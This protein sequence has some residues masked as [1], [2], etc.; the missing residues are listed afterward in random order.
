MNPMHAGDWIVRVL[1]SLEI[2]P[3]V[4]LGFDSADDMARHTGDL[5]INGLAPR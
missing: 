2:L 1:L 4:V 3:S 5:L